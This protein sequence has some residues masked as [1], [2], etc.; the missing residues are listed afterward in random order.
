MTARREARGFAALFGAALLAW[1]A[2]AIVI[3]PYAARAVLVLPGA[4]PAV[5]KSGP[6][7]VPPWP[8]RA[9]RQVER[10]TVHE[11]VVPPGDIHVFYRIGLTDQAALAA[12]FGIADPAALVRVLAASGR[13]SLGA[14]A[15]P[16]SVSQNIGKPLAVALDRAGQGLQLVDIRVDDRRAADIAGRLPTD[17][18]AGSL[19][20]ARADAIA[21]A[22]AARGQVATIAATAD[23]E[24]AETV[25]A[26]KLSVA[27][28]GGDRDAAR[29]GGRAFLLERYLDA[30]VAA[31]DSAPK[32]IID[33]RLNWPEPPVLDLRGLAAP[34]FGRG[35]I[36]AIRPAASR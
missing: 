26:A 15:T 11:V 30:L 25:A 20:K 28:F 17:E 21:V 2:S 27:R 14:G 5:L 16:D 36:D 9:L 3:V 22:A 29:A 35:D 18:G 31:A 32:T 13:A 24:A 4:P 12:T 34:A 1:G 10:G 8:F 7:L 19:A 23:A 6:H 33:H